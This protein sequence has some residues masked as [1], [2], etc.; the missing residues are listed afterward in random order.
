MVESKERF[1]AGPAEIRE[2][3]ERTKR[4]LRRLNLSEREAERLKR[5]VETLLR[6][7]AERYGRSA[8]CELELGQ[9]LGRAYIRIS[10]PGAEFDPTLTGREEEGNA[11]SERLL[12][13]LGLVPQWSRRRGVNSLTL[14]PRGRN[15]G[16]W[17][18]YAAALALSVVLTLALRTDTAATVGG[19]VLEQV[20]ETVCSIWRAVAAPLLFTTAVSVICGA[21]DTAQLGRHGRD[22]LARLAL[23]TLLW[24]VLGTAASALL[25]GL[26][27]APTLTAAAQVEETAASAQ[28]E[29]VPVLLAALAAGTVMALL[30]GRTARLR[31]MTE[32]LAELLRTITEYVCR[33][34]PLAVVAAV[35][36]LYKARAFR[37]LWKLPIY[38]IL[39]T[40]AATAVKLLAVSILRRISLPPLL[41]RLSGAMGETL[42]CVSTDSTIG[43]TMDNCEN[44]LGIS[45]TL[46]LLGLPVGNILCQPF[47]AAALTASACFAASVSSVEA[48]VAWLA[49]LALLSTFLAVALPHVPGALPF[50]MA[51][52]VRQLGLPGESLMLVAPVGFVLEAASAALTTVY[53]RLELLLLEHGENRHTKK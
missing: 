47:V 34:T 53:L 23:P 43:L 1:S 46:T 16:S 32:Q 14:C 13:G 4:F 12:I 25:F 7:I 39:L 26:R 44:E 28:P 48:G 35:P 40:L 27:F 17:L 21:A 37:T 10:Y 15:Y 49:E 2:A 18:T 19:A 36:L 6:R 41:K 51:L 42:K 9:R 8:Q 29:I 52:L 20:F 11:W 45:H 38:F 24:A 5:T 30:G 33:L 22:M 50:G 3:S 31:E